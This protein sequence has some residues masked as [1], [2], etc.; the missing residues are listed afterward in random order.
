MGASVVA[1]RGRSAASPFMEVG[2]LTALI[3]S[4]LSPSA[5]MVNSKPAEIQAAELVRVVGLGGLGDRLFGVG[6][7]AHQ[8]LAARATDGHRLRL[9]RRQRDGDGVDHVAV[10]A[11][12]D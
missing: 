11:E 9:A 12:P 4:A 3:V 7:G 10:D 6:L 8:P 5:S 1:S 2:A